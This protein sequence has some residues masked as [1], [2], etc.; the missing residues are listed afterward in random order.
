MLIQLFEMSL[1]FAMKIGSSCSKEIRHNG[2]LF[3]KQE[4]KSYGIKIRI[5]Q[6][7]EYAKFRVPNPTFNIQD[8]YIY[9]LGAVS[10]PDLLRTENLPSPD[11]SLFREAFWCTV[12][13]KRV[14]EQVPI[15][16]RNWS[17]HFIELH[18]ID[19]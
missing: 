5:E 19:F 2:R 1:R 14:E 4:S 11:P 12:A 17:S 3:N 15:C 16:F 8:F 13:E 6:R 9:C 18:S 10:H 7:G